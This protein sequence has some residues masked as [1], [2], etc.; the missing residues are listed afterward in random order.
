MKQTSRFAGF[1]LV[2]LLFL[3]STAE[4]AFNRLATKELRPIGEVEIPWWHQ[5]LDHIGLF[6]Q[7]FAST[8]AFGIIAYQL[9]R[10]ARRRDLYW[11]GARLGLVIAGVPF[12]GLGL[13]ALVGTLG[14]G[15]SF[16]FETAFIAMA[17]LLVL[18]QI[19][20]SGDLGVKIGILI[21]VTPLCVHYYGLLSLRVLEGEA[22][23]WGDLPERVL[24]Y[25]QWT[26]IL[27]ALASPYCFAPRPFLANISRPA[28]I[29][30]AM[31]VSVVCVMLLRQHYEVA[32]TLAENWLGIDIGPGAPSSSLVT[33][34]FAVGTVTWTMTACVTA[35]AV[36]RRDI[37]VGLGLVVVSG[38]GF[39]WPIQFLVGMVGLMAIAEAAAKVE[40][41]ELEVVAQL[42]GFRA[43]PIAANV[44]QEYVGAVAAA[45]GTGVSSR[46]ESREKAEGD[47]G[48]ENEGD[49]GGDTNGEASDDGAD[50]REDVREQDVG[51]ARASASAVTIYG[52]DQ[53]HAITHIV[54]K[55]HGLD[56]LLRIERYNDSVIA[57]EVM[58][59]GQPDEGVEPEWTLYARPDRLLGIGAHPE[60][61]ATSAPVHKVDDASFEQRFRVR[62]GGGLTSRIL[63]ADSRS[64][65]IALIDGWVALWPDCG[66]QYR[67]YPGRGAPLDHPLPIT[68]LAFRGSNGAASAERIVSVIELLAGIAAR[69]LSRGDRS[70]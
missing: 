27:A 29:I 5:V 28:P 4:L 60:P 64:S 65:C 66:L 43:P 53:E 30:M 6:C 47:R 52:D 22:A 33:Y 12:L 63:D 3:V 56:V 31:F 25:G 11:T 55:R 45:L 17:V 57:V 13:L 61:P 9:W 35:D 69:A 62:D 42:R 54:S 46:P 34:A 20:R 10:L 2:H 24:L 37:G 8:L 51:K 16:W 67:V 68:E 15:A 19:T 59:G 23:M 49:R 26:M 21:L 41:E 18:C 1:E 38:Y 48:E 50:G 44:W 14:A 70:G 7:Y 58:C 40:D 36:S 32:M 39:A